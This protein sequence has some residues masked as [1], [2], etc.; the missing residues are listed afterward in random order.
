[1]YQ[2]WD[3]K[4]K[5]LDAAAGPHVLGGVDL[6]VIATGGGAIDDQLIT[7]NLGFKYEK[8]KA[9]NYM[10]YGIFEPSKDGDVHLMKENMEDVFQ[11]VT[12]GMQSPMRRAR[13]RKRI[14][15]ISS[16]I[17]PGSRRRTSTT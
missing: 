15:S 12:G 17:S 14:F 3:D 8:L 1:M 16:P 2:K 13:A 9:K 4:A 11:Q 10:A 5:K 7:R 6:L